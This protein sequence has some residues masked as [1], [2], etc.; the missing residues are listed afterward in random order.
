M[1]T[2]RRSLRTSRYSTYSPSES[3]EFPESA[4]HC[5][6]KQFQNKTAHTETRERSQ[7]VKVAVS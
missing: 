1:L 7:L 5:V 6:L 4:S 3:Q 2:L